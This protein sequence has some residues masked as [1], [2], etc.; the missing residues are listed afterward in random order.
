MLDLL[1][2]AD[3]ILR[4]AAHEMH[5]MCERSVAHPPPDLSDLSDSDDDPSDGDGSATDAASA[6]PDFP[7][8]CNHVPDSSGVQTNSSSSPWAA[9]AGGGTFDDVPDICPLGYTPTTITRVY[10][11]PEMRVFF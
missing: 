7:E 5:L 4:D 9:H 2:M 8:P 11:T 1:G 10:A 6:S 3:A